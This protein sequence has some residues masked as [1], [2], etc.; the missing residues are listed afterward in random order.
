MNRTVYFIVYLLCLGVTMSASAATQ[1]YRASLLYFTADPTRDANATHYLEDGLLLIRDGHVVAASD[2]ASVPAAQ[3]RQLT[4]TDYRGKLLLPGF[5][6]THIH[7]PQ[8]EMIA[9]YGEQ[10]LEWLNSYT[11]PTER[12]FADAGY[13]RQR[14][15][16][17]INE[18]LRNGTTTALVFATVHPQSVDAL[19]EAADAKQMRLI[20]GKVL[21]DRNAPDY[22]RDTAQRGYDESR[23]LIRKWHHHGRLLYAVTP[24]F[25]PTSTPQQLAL[26]GKLLQEFPDVYLQTHLS[27][28]KNEI[29]WV[30]SLFPERKGYLDVYD[31]YGLAG[32][33]SVFAHAIHLE[34]GEAQT[35]AAR[36]AAVAFC[37]T[38]NLFLGS[39]LFRLHPLKQAGVRVGLGTDVGAGTSF[40]MLQTLNEGYKVQQLQGEKLSAREG[41]YQATLGGAEALQL[42]DRIGSFQPG[43][44]ADFVVLEWGATPLQQLRQSQARTLDDRLFALMMQGD[45][46]NVVATYV[47][48]E[49]AY[50]RP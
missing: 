41:L 39:G 49:Q 42:A 8:T 9:S 21:M 18:L 37:P 26:A 25:A 11:F 38:S 34:D 10:L 15:G 35:L 1:A 47:N 30:K 31:H 36:G 33:R 48:G 19:F 29:A 27:E 17:F 46:R 50:R 40:S 6:D 3:R 44:E 2:Y 32:P 20:A 14:A 28:N 7:F 13:A 24:R 16:F 43:R 4:I 5:V 22:L 12:K 23:A 45:D